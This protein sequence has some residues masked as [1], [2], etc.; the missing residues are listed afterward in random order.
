MRTVLIIK[1]YGIY[2]GTS[3]LAQSNSKTQA[4]KATVVKVQN[5][6]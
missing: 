3:K 4:S 6:K 5:A 1:N 2:F